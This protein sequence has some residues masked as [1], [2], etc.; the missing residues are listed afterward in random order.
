MGEEWDG[1]EF[2]SMVLV[3]LEEWNGQEGLGYEW[4]GKVGRGQARSSKVL[5]KIIGPAWNGMEGTGMEENS[6][7]MTD[8]EMLKEIYIAVHRLEGYVIGSTDGF[9]S[10]IDS[11]DKHLYELQSFIDAVGAEKWRTSGMGD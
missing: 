6:K 1:K 4:L 11:I 5:G 8:R 10:R 2:N 7:V 3:R 9:V